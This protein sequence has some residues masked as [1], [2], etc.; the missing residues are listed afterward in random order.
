MRKKMKMLSIPIALVLLMALLVSTAATAGQSRKRGND[1]Q[2]DGYKP[3]LTPDDQRAPQNHGRLMVIAN[4]TVTAEMLETLGELGT[5]HGVIDRYNVIAMTARGP[6]ARQAIA[7][8]SFV[9]SMENDRRLYLNDFGTWDRDILDVSDVEETID[10]AALAG[11]GE[12]GRAAILAEAFADEREVE[13]TGAGVH[14]AVIDT[15]LP[16][17]WRTFLPEDSVDTDLARAFMGGG[18]VAEDFVPWDQY[19]ISN[20]D[21]MWEHD[22][23]GHGL[24]VASHV[25]GFNFLGR[26]AD[27]VAPD[28]KIIP[29]KVFPNGQAFTW[30]SRIIAA[31]AYATELKTSG[32]VEQL[33]INMSLG[34]SAP[35]ELD[36]EAINDA[37]GADVIVVASAGNAGEA[38]MGW[39]GAYPEVISAGATGWTEQFR[40]L[41]PKGAPN[42]G[43]WWTQDVD[44]DPDGTG[45]S[46]EQQSYVTF[47]SSRAIPELSEPFEGVPA[48]ELDV[49]APGLWTVAPFGHGPNADYFFIG[50]T[51]F[52]SPLTAGVA[53][54]MLEANPSLE[55]GDV[56]DI[57][58]STALT[59]NANDNRSDVL[60]PFIP[61]LTDGTGT[62]D[63]AW[64]TA[65]DHDG[66]DSTPALTCDPVGHGLLQADDALGAVPSP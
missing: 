27:G 2:V 10:F 55:Q 20:P 29:L 18:A 51:S 66:D 57:M 16:R 35:G 47:F 63:P 46:E 49:M 21:G 7:G 41:S 5:V 61:S 12:E 9:S 19:H 36:R 59:M 1:L 28:A 44:N 6:Q 65:C 60:E 64:D 33:V 3:V 50:G 37:I 4:S 25:V 40:P 48:Q 23:N 8:L 13:Y 62:Y 31:I 42:T 24:A 58:K 39:P 52:S 38:G 22:T 14:V 34:G 15:G 30:S 54:L 53:A 45:T 32:A 17:N 43:F 11:A 26:P 56:E